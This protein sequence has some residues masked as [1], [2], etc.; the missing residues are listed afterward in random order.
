MFV[1]FPGQGDQALRQVALF[2]YRT[3][4]YPIQVAYQRA[5]QQLA[6]RTVLPEADFAY[7]LADAFDHVQG[8]RQHGGTLGLVQLMS[9]A[10]F[11]QDQAHEWYLDL[12]VQVWEFVAISLPQ[13]LNELPQLSFQRIP[14][15]FKALENLL[16]LFTHLPRVSRVLVREADN[17]VASRVLHLCRS[18]AAA[19]LPREDTLELGIGNGRGRDFWINPTR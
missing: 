18:G 4:P 11:F 17:V 16:Q 13:C 6:H 14:V 3:H 12:G 7:L 19:G 2:P 5:R 8:R 9:F 10:A 15:V 1:V